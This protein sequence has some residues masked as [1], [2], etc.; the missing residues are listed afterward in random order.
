MPSSLANRATVALLLLGTAVPLV[1]Q[2]PRVVTADDYTRAEKFLA[3]WTMPL[4]Y[5]TGVRPTWLSSDRFWYRTTTPA[6]AQFVVVDPARG[7]RSPAFDA[8]RIAAGL[9]AATGQR[10][11]ATSLPF[12]TFEYTPNGLI[13]VRVGRRTFDCNQ[14]TG[15]CG[16]AMDV[17]EEMRASASRNGAPPVGISPDG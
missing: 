5:G 2:Q 8:A 12:S 1:A 17:H 7:S 15:R 13:R 4:V 3:P 14:E 16:E 6:G 10:Y 11:E 9:S